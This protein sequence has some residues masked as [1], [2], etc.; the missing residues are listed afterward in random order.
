MFPWFTSQPPPKAPQTPYE[1][2]LQRLREGVPP[3]LA[4]RAAGIQWEEI[5]DS[6]EVDKALAEGEILL[7]ERARDI[8]VT[9]IVRSAMRHEARTW[10]PKA[11]PNPGATLEDYLR[12]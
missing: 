8:G 12:D 11:E 1:L 5:K 9:G 3:E 6:P 4:T 7:F 2:L 10:Q